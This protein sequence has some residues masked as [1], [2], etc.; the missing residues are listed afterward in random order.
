MAY[1]NELGRE[2]KKDYHQNR[3]DWS[4]NGFSVEGIVANNSYLIEH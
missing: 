4:K 2:S 1:E 3:D